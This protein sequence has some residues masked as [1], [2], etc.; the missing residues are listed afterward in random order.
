MQSMNI[1]T[2]PAQV[3]AG[4]GL[5]L[6]VFL[7]VCGSAIGIYIT[8]ACVVGAIKKKPEIFISVL[9]LALRP[10]TQGIYGFFGFILYSSKVNPQISFFNSCIIFGAGLTLGVVNLIS[11]IKQ[12]ETCA[13][14]INAIGNGYNVLAQTHI[15]GLFIEFF[16][17]LSLVA[18]ILMLNIL[19]K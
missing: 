4:L 3:L 18:S 15:L 6:M 2:L 16:A 5:S 9:T 14:G 1:I 11:G 10:A 8:G 13:C 7:S 17:I 12:G 19:A